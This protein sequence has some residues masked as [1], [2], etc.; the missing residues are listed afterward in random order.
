MRFL[1]AIA[2]AALSLLASSQSDAA[3][4][5]D[6]DAIRIP[7]IQRRS[8]SITNPNGSVNLAF[9]NEEVQATVV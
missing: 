6:P 4:E 5:E 3:F 1:L 2:V 8:E 7:L 9:L